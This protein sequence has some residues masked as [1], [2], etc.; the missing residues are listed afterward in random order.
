MKKNKIIITDIIIIAGIIFIIFAG[1]KF[2]ND[3]SYTM[4]SAAAAVLS[5]I[6]FYL[7]YD[8]KDKGVVDIVLVSV[9]ISLIVAGRFVFAVTPFFKPVTALVIITGFYLGKES[10]F[11]TG[12]ISALISNMM[13]GQ[14]P[15]T[16]FQMFVWGMTGFIAGLFADR[17]ITDSKVFLVIYSVLAGVLF[18][19]SMDVWTVISIDGKFD[20]DRYKV[21]LITSVPVMIIYIVSDIVFLIALKKSMGKRFVRIKNK[22]GSY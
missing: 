14:G 3:R 11:V 19:M 7:S 8:M 6:P 15:W 16:P 10:G 20:I 21:A 18:S 22:Y 17:K 2:L 4:I 5:C 12:S 13:F 9:M 1:V